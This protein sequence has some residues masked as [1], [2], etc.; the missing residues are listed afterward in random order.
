MSMLFL[1]SCQKETI[2]NTSMTLT[3]DWYMTDYQAFS[4]QPIVVN[5]GDILWSFDTIAQT[6]TIQNSTN[7]FNPSGTYA[8][9]KT[10]TELTVV[11]PDYSQTFD[12]S[13]VN[14]T[15][16]LSDS[17]ELDGPIITFER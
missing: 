13:F 11:F 12:Y 10:A 5:R 15:L 16:V 1:G 6:I 2:K 14:N 17:P 7:R 4:P 9:N 3:G 8:Y